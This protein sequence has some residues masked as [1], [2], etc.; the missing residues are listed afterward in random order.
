MHR[1]LRCDRHRNLR[2]PCTHRVANA[3]QVMVRPSSQLVCT[4][5]S[6]NN[7]CIASCGV[8]VIATCAHLAR[9]GSP[10]HC[11]LWC[12]RHRNLCAYC[13]RRITDV[14]QV[15]AR[16]LNKPICAHKFQSKECRLQQVALH[17]NAHVCSYS[18]W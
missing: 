18:H 15:A 5:Q 10:T 6:Q 7:Q 4:L 1:K 2:A 16:A 3:L 11:K 12:D 13:N 14:S 8:T 17:A 9:P